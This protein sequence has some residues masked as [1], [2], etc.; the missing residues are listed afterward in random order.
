VNQVELHIYLQQ[1]ELV[2]F[3][4]K[5]GI[6]VEA[7]SPLVHGEGMDNEVL[8]AIAKKHGKSVAQIMLRWCIQKDT[9]VLPKSVHAERIREN[10]E[11]FDFELDA[12]DMQRLARLERNLRTAWDPTHVQ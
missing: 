11:L 4:Q 3:C 6:V 7:Y 12:E 9:V 1:P 2:E 10:L 8:Q 5:H